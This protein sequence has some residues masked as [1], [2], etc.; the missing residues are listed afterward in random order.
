MFTEGTNKQDF[1]SSLTTYVGGAMEFGQLAL[2][3]FFADHGDEGLAAGTGK[4]G[5]LIFTGTLGAMRTNAQYAS[6]GAGR[7]G[8]RML[9]QALAKE[10]SEKGVHV[11]HV[12]ANGGIEDAQGQAQE[13]GKRIS[14]DSVGRTYLWLSR[15]TVDLWVHELDMRPACERF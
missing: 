2:A 5:T 14:A 15:Q 4:K 6:Y 1:T 11:A 10:F 13:E 8:V 3:R 7:A 12:I 9:A